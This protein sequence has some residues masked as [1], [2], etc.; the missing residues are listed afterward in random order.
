MRADFI[1]RELERQRKENEKIEAGRKQQL[2]NKLQSLG[3]ELNNIEYHDTVY[4]KWITAN[5]TN[6]NEY[7]KV[8]VQVVSQNKANAK[9]QSD[10]LRTKATLKNGKTINIKTAK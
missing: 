10:Y 8:E 9:F 1:K 6:H 7:D 3:L 2:T 5:V 4:G